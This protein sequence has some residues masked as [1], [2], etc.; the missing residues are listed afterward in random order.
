V[1]CVRFVPQQSLLLSGSGDTLVALWDTRAGK[2]VNRIHGAA[3][4]GP[5]GIDVH[6]NVVVLGNN[7]PERG[8]QLFDLRK[9]LAPAAELTLPLSPATR[10]W[11]TP[12][13]SA[14]WAVRFSPDGTFLAVGGSSDFRVFDWKRTVAEGTTA[15]AAASS[16]AAARP[17]DDGKSRVPA[18]NGVEA[19]ALKLDGGSDHAIFSVAWHP[20]GH[21]LGCVGY[22]NYI[23]ALRKIA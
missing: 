9:S 2:S 10:D 8:V 12:E 23:A 11:V 22:G 7:R 19:G 5:D 21:F 20:S 6:G 4:A 3:V 14:V 13:P 15:T 17:D 1:Q 18:L 16:S